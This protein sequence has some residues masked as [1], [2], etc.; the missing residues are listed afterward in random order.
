MCDHDYPIR[1]YSDYTT[2]RTFCHTVW[3]CTECDMQLR[4]DTVELKPK[5]YTVT[6]EQA[7]AIFYVSKRTIYRRIKEGKLVKWGGRSLTLVELR[8]VFGKEPI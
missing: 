3:R 4:E 5:A 8:R 7:A 6:V 1:T 2:N